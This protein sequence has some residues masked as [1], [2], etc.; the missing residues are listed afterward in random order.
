MLVRAFQ[1]Q[2]QPPERT[3]VEASSFPDLDKLAAKRSKI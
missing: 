3:I 2:V 1:A